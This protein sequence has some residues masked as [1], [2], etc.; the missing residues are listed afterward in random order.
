MEDPAGR[1]TKLEYDAAGNL[2]KI[3]DPDNKARTFSYDSQRHITK[4]IDKR[5]FSEQTLYD[6]AGRATGGIRKDG[7]QLQVAPVQ[8]QGLYRKE[9]TT[10]PL[11]APVAQPLST[12]I[13]ASYADGSGGVVTQILDQTGQVVSA[14]DGGGNKPSF[15]RNQNLLVTKKTDARGNTTSYEYDAKGNVK[16]ISDLLSGTPQT[17][18]NNNGQLFEPRNYINANARAIAVGDVNDNS[19]VDIVTAGY[20]N[21][22][23]VLLGN[24]DGTFG[25][26]DYTV[27]DSP[28]SI[29][30]GDLNGDLNLDIIT[31]SSFGGT[32]PNA[33]RVSV[34]LGDGSGNFTPQANNYPVAS[35]A[36][37]V[38]V[39]DVNKDGENDVV[40][41]NNSST[42]SLSV[43][44]GNG[45]GTFAPSTNIALNSS[46]EFATLNDL[47]K[48]GNL[49][50]IAAS[51]SS[52]TNPASGRVSVLLGNGSGTFATQSNY[53]MN[54]GAVSVAVGDLNG[55]G[56]NDIITANKRDSNVSASLNNDVSVLL[57]NGDG[58][59]GVATNYS[60]QSITGDFHNPLSVAVGDVDGD[61]DLD[62]VISGQGYGLE[63]V[64]LNNG[65]GTLAIPSDDNYYFSYASDQAVA[66]ADIDLD[67]DLDLIF[68]SGGVN[69]RLNNNVQ[70]SGGGGTGKRSYT[71]DPVFNQVT[72]ETDELGRQTLYEIDQLTGNRR[73]VTNVVGAVGDSD[74]VVTSYTYTNKN[75]IDIETDPNGRVTDYDYNDKDQL[76]K[77]T[78]AK[79]T[80][81]EAVQQFEYDAAGNQKAVI[82]ENGIRTEYEYD[83][84]N[85]LKK[86]TF[87]K[88]TPD[89]ATQQFE[90]DGAGNQTATIDENGNRTE[91]EYNIM[92]QLVKVKAPDPD[93][94]GPLTSPVTSYEY[95]KNGNQVLMLDPLGRRT[96]YRY[97]SRNRL[98]E[99]VNP[100]GSKEKMRYDSDNNQTASF[101]AKANRTNKVYDA[102]GR[103]IREVD[104]SDKITR[105]EYDVAN[106]MVAQVDAN[107]S[108][109]EYKYDDLGRRTDVTEG[110][111][112][113]IASTSKTEYDKVGNVTAEI[114][115]NNNKT[116]YVYDARNRQTRVIDALTPSG[117]TTTEYDKVGNVLSVTD[118]LLRKT[119][120][121]YDPLNR[122]KTVTDPRLNT[123][124]YT[125]DK[126]GNRTK[127]TDALNHSTEYTFDNLNRQIGTKNPLTSTTKSTYDANSNLLRFT[128][129]L[130]EETAYVYDKKDRVTAVT[131]PLGNTVT[132][133][134]DANGNVSAVTDG[135]GNTTRYGYDALNRQTTVTDA[136][137]KVTTTTY[138]NVGNIAS[139][140][141][142]ANNKTTYAYDELNRL[143]TETNLPLNRTRSYTYDTASN[144]ITAKDG[145]NRTR[146]FVYDKL[147]RPTE[148]QW[149]NSANTPIRTI[150]S[151]YDAAGQLKTISDPD[152]TYTL[153]YD[154]AG[155]LETVDNAGTPN[156]PN[157]LLKYTYN[158]V[159]NP[160]SVTDTINGQLR[161]TK[162]FTYD[163][164]NRVTRITQSGNGV[165]SKRVDMSYDAAGKTK[166]VIR[167][168]DLNGTNLVAKSEYVYDSVGRL[169]RL[170]HGKGNVAL[171]NYAWTYDFANRVTGFNSPSGSTSYSYDKLDQL[172]GAD[173]TTQS[174][175]NYS[176]DDNGNRTNSGYQ[177]GSNNQLNSDGVYNYEYD[178]EGNLRKR[179][180]IVTGEVTEYSWDYRNRLTQVVGKNSGGSVIKSAQYSYDGLNRRIVREVDADGAGS[181]AP[182]VERLVYDG[183]H[184]ALTFD[185]GGNQTHRYLHGVQTDEILADESAGG[186]VL[187]PLTDNLGTVRDL[188]DSN[189]AIQNR[190]GYDSFG[191]VR[192]Q[193]NPSVGFRFG[194][195]GRELDSETGNY[196]YN[197]RYYDPQVGR[198]ISEDT[199]GF[200][201]G[202]AN[203][204][205]YV[206]N[207]S[208]NYTDPTGEL[209]PTAP[210]V[211]APPV[212]APPGGGLIP[213]LRRIPGLG[214]AG[215]LLA[216]PGGGGLLNPLP[217]GQDDRL[218]EERLRRGLIR[219]HGQ[220]QPTPSLN[221]P[222]PYPS[223]TPAPAPA[224]APKSASP[225][226]TPKKK[227]SNCP[228]CDDP[229]FS[230]YDKCSDLV[231]NDLPFE[232]YK[233]TTIKSAV[234]AMQNFR[235]NHPLIKDFRELEPQGGKGDPGDK[236]KCKNPTGAN[237]YNVYIKDLFPKKSAGS[238]AECTCCKE[239]N[240]PD[241][242]SRFAILNIKDKYDPPT[243]YYNKGR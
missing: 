63:S 220:T 5:G 215:I 234:K 34:L 136:L 149:L 236:F 80:P 1:L 95:D 166:D 29:A 142:P 221:R 65:N 52:G 123:T 145:N 199:I 35:G 201:G 30:L 209:I 148:E 109:T 172:T 45:N 233:D 18:P 218:F 157:V 117:S 25:V 61:G 180:D 67:S 85:Q 15:E 130:G 216:P 178:G 155:N 26:R 228:T 62:A 135:L 102:R 229:P 8:V 208:T 211:A 151:S 225:T 153:T 141:D 202:D 121:T 243:K 174:D 24:G 170:S 38:A 112:T 217:A 33:G 20:G 70:A 224:S 81:D 235:G 168:S 2:Q 203:L 237:H 4:E 73:K 160:L 51:P 125:Y 176:Y 68:A 126:A 152:A 74:D 181:A 111:T 28:N 23:S 198:F 159:N 84:M 242:V 86:T 77:I 206:G 106:Q 11:N 115:G 156:I 195:T 204:Y 93:G 127:I 138:D 184:I 39:G 64:F 16:S 113:A 129:E 92:N 50:I 13:E 99:T 21:S 96:E 132:T 6:F 192:S 71:Y 196:Y 46:P 232:G 214:G 222:K 131:D 27:S 120:F 207:S 108:R 10:N 82:D 32:T 60:I 158:K 116:Q 59:F 83:A 91:S 197:S 114:D 100:D 98:V 189:G 57:S 144:L 226:R 187:W 154:L 139:I 137:N 75:L 42:N 88:A 165:S 119:S 97:D 200:A 56:N 140:T 231:T 7:S 53:S 223:P 44:L 76:V 190:I 124:T 169:T 105:F 122:Q 49:D 133:E 227:G 188:V 150:A 182:Q 210:P 55:D 171:A 239:G 37:S 241:L 78:V 36:L 54:V 19:T 103:L 128:N 17:P 205:R 230:S 183:Q 194:F 118:P 167:Y 238:I 213:F 146:K 186:S 12:V 147:N 161:G 110:A 79:G 163:D 43:L 58:S 193:T 219:P 47:N 173:Y 185:G 31:V 22:V 177:R 101:D 3:V 41:A 69:V 94:S 191:K 134:Y 240:P 9:D 179:T 87:A 162:S 48:D 40:T 164:G 66:L 104:P 72:S 89:E 175:E 90:Y 212:A 14:V 143:K 107:N